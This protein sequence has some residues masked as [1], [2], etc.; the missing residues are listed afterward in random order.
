MP[1]D[2]INALPQKIRDNMEIWEEGFGDLHSHYG[3]KGGN[4]LLCEEV[5]QLEVGNDT[6]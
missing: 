2:V 3:C 4:H 5:N 6:L 1:T